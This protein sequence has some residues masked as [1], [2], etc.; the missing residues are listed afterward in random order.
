VLER[1]HRAAPTPSSSL[2]V[3]RVALRMIELILCMQKRQHARRTSR[4]IDTVLWRL[5]ALALC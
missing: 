4:I 5:L 2:T 3:R 1:T